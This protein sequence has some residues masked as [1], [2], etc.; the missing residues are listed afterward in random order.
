M[1]VVAEGLLA[2]PSNI[3]ELLA[4]GGESG[5][6]A[7]EVFLRQA[8]PIWALEPHHRIQ[9]SQAPMRE[10]R[11]EARLGELHAALDGVRATLRSIETS[12]AELL[13]QTGCATELSIVPGLEIARPIPIVVEDSAADAVVRWPE[14]GLTGVGG[15][16]GEAIDSLREE[17]A[18]TWHELQEDS[19]FR[20]TRHART[21]RA[22]LEYYAKAPA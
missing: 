22:V 2:S 6:A 13:S 15:S 10:L 16:E 20:L 4:S 3:M 11:I 17:I 9:Q 1:E 8:E 12:L 21:I 5:T 14:A 7:A 19:D 18:T